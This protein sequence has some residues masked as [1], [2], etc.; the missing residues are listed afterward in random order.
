[1]TDA[2]KIAFVS[3]AHIHSRAFLKKIAATPGL[4]PAGVWDDVPERGKAY[5]DEFGTTFEPDLARLV[6]GEA[7]AFVVCAENT[8]HLGVLEHVLP[9]GKPVL[10]EKPLAT[11]LADARRIRQLADEHHTPLTSG[12]FQ[13]FFG[14]HRAAM[15]AMAAGRLGKVTNLFFRNAHHAAFGRWFDNPDLAWF[16]KPD[17]AGG[18]AMLDLGTHAVHLLLHVAAAA[19]SR[20]CTHVRADMANLAGVYPDVEDWGVIEMTF[21]DGRRARVESAWI[22]TTP[23]TGLE[24][25]GT[26]AGLQVRH[27]D[28]NQVPVL[29]R[30]GKPDEPLDLAEA[31]PDRIDRLAAMARG[32]LPADELADDLAACLQ[33]VAVMEAAYRSAAAG[34]GRVD[35]ESV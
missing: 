5:A 35:V 22:A 14:H 31:R 1:M 20:R 2:V 34:G 33:A 16:T 26:D 25:W 12:Y 3:T 27:V 18:G 24:A 13:P 30:P 9:A 4:E 15:D 11:T 23:G 10:C 29:T 28:A 32:Q 19:G 6:G 7:D 17:L 8:R 21:D